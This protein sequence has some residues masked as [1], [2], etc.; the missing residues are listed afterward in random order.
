MDVWIEPEADAVARLAADF[1]QDAV[2]AGEITLGLATGSTPVATYRELIRRHREEGL[3]FDRVHVV[4]LDEYVGIAPDHPQSYR[5]FIRDTFTNAVGI[6]PDR[7]H[8][9]AGDAVDLAAAGA[10]YE[11]LLQRLPPRALQLLGIGRD[12][13]IGF[14]EPTSSLASRTR[15]K[16][17]HP[18]TRAD[19][20]RF[21][22]DSE[23]VPVHAL[24]M[25]IGT[26]LEARRLV[27]LATGDTKAAA[28]AAA[29]EGPVSASVPAS[30][31]QL[32][33]AAM[34]VIDEAAAGGLAHRAYHAEVAAHRPAWQR[35]GAGA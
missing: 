28:V 34:V 17:L 35:P 14:N 23:S 15:V 33:P 27:L 10:D 11:A 12:G 5:R 20:A 22:A 8:G 1:V 4:L 31:L 16:T 13:H 6:A 3:S 9:P 2:G 18:D 32:H 7:V 19:N 29:V 30:A 24:T 25:G 26:I 21:F